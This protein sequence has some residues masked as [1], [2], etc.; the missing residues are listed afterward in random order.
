MLCLLAACADVS[1]NA[2]AHDGGEEMVGV[3]AIAGADCDDAAFGGNVT[4]SPPARTFMDAALSGSI[5]NPE[6]STGGN[7]VV[8]ITMYRMHR[9]GL[10]ITPFRLCH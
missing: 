4:W 2:M 5:Y 10:S 3:T 9:D 8:I 6:T 1:G 7:I